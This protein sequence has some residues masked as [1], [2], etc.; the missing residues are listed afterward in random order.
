MSTSYKTPAF[1]TLCALI[2]ILGA[3]SSDPV[4]EVDSGFEPLESSAPRGPET[5]VDIPAPPTGLPESLAIS[6]DGSKIAFVAPDGGLGLLWVHDL[7]SGNSQTFPQTEDAARPF[8][9]PDGRS[10]GFFA[11]GKFRTIDLE[12]GETEALANLVGSTGG[13]WTRD[14]T[15]LISGTATVIRSVS[16]DGR[17]IA[18]VT[19]LIPG[20]TGHRFPHL[21]PD[22]RHF[23]YF[24]TG[25]PEVRG[26]YIGEI[27]T[28]SG[29][30]GN[31]FG[32]SQ[33]GPPTRLAES[34]SEAWYAPSGHLLL[35]RG[36]TLVAQ[37]FDPNLGE[38][39]GDPFP[40]AD[41][42]VVR[43]LGDAAISTSMAGH[44]VPKQAH[45]EW[46]TGRMAAVKLEA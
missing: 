6:P 37:S 16:A 26:V 46:T 3:C 32:R 23:L 35:V 9:S 22:G 42:I 28:G 39:T 12:T 5:R 1:L 8:W 45:S 17:D 36:G 24:A 30:L 7:N 4:P 18:L 25:D 38:L 13:A 21:L 40:V 20:Q 44:L 34:D 19:T 14:G 31:L 11:K 41:D 10:I 2:G 15:F 27:S 33:T 43:N 29:G